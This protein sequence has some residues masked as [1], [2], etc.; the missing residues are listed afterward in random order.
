MTAWRRQLHQAIPAR[1]R[2]TFRDLRVEGSGPGREAAAVGLGVFLGCLPFYGF[3]LLLCWVLGWL[4]GLNRLKVYLAAN[5]SNPFVAPWLLLAELQTGAWLRHGAF[6][7]LAPRAIRS[8]GWD[9]VLVDL[10]VGSVA[11][12]A[13]LSVIAAAATY[14]LVRNAGD[15]EGFLELV[16]RTAERYVGASIVAWE[17]ARGKLRGDPIYRATLCGDLL[18]SGGTLLDIGCGQGLMLALLAEARRAEDAGEWPASLP[19]P[20]R[21]NR[22]TGVELRPRVAAA[23]QRALGEDAEI[24]PGNASE[25]QVGPVHAGLLFDVLQM[26]STAEQEAMIARLASRLDRDGVILVREADADAGW[27]FLAVWM[28]NKAKALAFGHWGQRFCFRSRTEWV[29]CFDSHGLRTEVRAMGAGTPF[30][31]VLFSLTVKADDPA[32]DRPGARPA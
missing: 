20:P 2:H 4:F 8:A 10:I 11:V 19:R 23:A 27:R 30:A 16:R 18:R 32:P 7:S 24:V 6:Q 12:G 5:I 17:F 9:V 26:M 25:A 3:H 22:M 29:A 31:N 15:D 28:G 13:C 21:F 1:I 14:A